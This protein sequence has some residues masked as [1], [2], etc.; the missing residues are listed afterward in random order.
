LQP[1]K[2]VVPLRGFSGA[3]KQQFLTE[4]VVCERTRFWGIAA[5]ERA[6]VGDPGKWGGGHR[7]LVEAKNL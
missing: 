1:E 4:E 7:C 2:R 5:V 6:F 3:G